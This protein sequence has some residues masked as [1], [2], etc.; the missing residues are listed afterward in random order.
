MDIHYPTIY[1]SNKN[2]DELIKIFGLY[3]I[4]CFIEAAQPA[5]NEHMKR[6][7]KEKLSSIWIQNVFSP[8]DM[9]DYFL[10]AIK[11]NQPTNGKE[12]LVKRFDNIKEKQLLPST[13]RLA[14][15]HFLTI[16]YEN[17]SHGKPLYELDLETI[18]KMK[19]TLKKMYPMYYKRLLEAAL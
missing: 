12:D 15:N 10:T 11:N 5:T 2:L 19:R 6:R 7:D 1:T 14:E 4:Y 13:H 16:V 3:V 8:I 18:K 17:F 9:Y